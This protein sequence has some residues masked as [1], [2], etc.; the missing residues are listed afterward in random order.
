MASAAS[1]S[2]LFK[3]IAPFA[4]LLKSAPHRDAT[5]IPYAQWLSLYV[6]SL[7]K[8]PHTAAIA[9]AKRAEKSLFI[10]QVHDIVDSMLLSSLLASR[11]NQVLVPSNPNELQSM[12]SIERGNSEKSEKEKG[13]AQMEATRSDLWYL[14]PRDDP[15]E[16][17]SA[18]D[19]CY[20][21]EGGKNNMLEVFTPKFM[22]E[23]LL[24]G[25]CLTH[26]TAELRRQGELLRTFKEDRSE[27]VGKGVGKATP[28]SSDR[29]V[30]LTIPFSCLWQIKH[31]AHLRPSA[32]ATATSLQERCARQSLLQG[33]H[34][35]FQLQADLKRLTT[36]PSAP[37]PL[38]KLHLSR[39][40]E[41]FEMLCQLPRVREVLLT[42][43]GADPNPTTEV[44]AAIRRNLSLAAL[45]ERT[46]IR[47]AYL[48]RYSL[49]RAYIR[50]RNAAKANGETET[51]ETSEGFP[52]A[53][54][55]ISHPSEQR[56]FR[57]LGVPTLSHAS[58]S[59][60]RN[61]KNSV[62]IHKKAMLECGEMVRRMTTREENLRQSGLKR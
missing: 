55:M 17:L 37:A 5:H 2:S 29:T 20:E 56:L 45:C 44:D 10:Q 36:P 14:N 3:A 18:A 1:G 40:T 61:Q 9:D 16:S 8:A 19:W 49:Y 51:E 13:G 34:H 15:T 33:I 41:E 25:S 22:T 39:P 27:L 21:V 28:T 50:R 12:I 6:D 30:H 4:A 31:E 53:L 35:A 43:R 7:G 59:T 11:W 23:P 57:S 54:V 47:L 42:L 38:I 46:P 52:S 62:S 24:G 60:A 32:S 58:A 48:L 26:W